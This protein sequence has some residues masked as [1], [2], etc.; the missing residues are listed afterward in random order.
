MISFSPEP[1]PFGGSKSR[2]TEMT[3]VSLGFAGGERVAGE[4]GKGM[5]WKVE[6]R[7]NTIPSGG[8]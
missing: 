2:E 8:F 3:D 4:A 1:N 7:Q 6:M 5:L